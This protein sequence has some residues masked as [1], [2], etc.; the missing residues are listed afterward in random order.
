LTPA[1]GRGIIGKVERSAP[2]PSVL[3]MDEPSLEGRTLLQVVHAFPPASVTGTEQHVFG[4]S[5]ELARSNRVC[6]FTREVRPDLPEYTALDDEL[7]GVRVRRLTMPRLNG[8]PARLARICDAAL[9]GAFTRYLDETAPDL[10]HVHHALDLSLALATIAKRRGVP[11]VVTLHDY[12]FACPRIN[13]VRGDGSLCDGPRDGRRCGPC[14]AA[15]PP[16]PA[17]ITPGRLRLYLRHRLRPQARLEAELGAA[18]TELARQAAT[19][20]AHQGP[21]PG[22]H[23][24]LFALRRAWAAYQLAQ[25]D[26]L[27]A[28][29]QSTASIVSSQCPGLRPIR[30]V[31]HGIDV[32]RFRAV[33]RTSS[34]IVRF[35]FLGSVVKL[36]GVEVLLRAF[37]RLPRGAAALAI[38][39]IAR[40]P[41]F[42]E[43][44]RLLAG[45][46]GASM[47]GPY[48][49][50]DLARLLSEI[51]VVAV[52]SLV[53][54]SFGLVVR[55]AFAGGAPVIASRI[56]ALTEA[57]RDG[58]DGLL[59]KPG[60]AR[61][62]A[63]AM[64]RFVDEPGLL[65]AM[66]AHLPRVKTTAEN[67]AEIAAIYRELL[68]GPRS[69]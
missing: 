24:D 48:R 47:G 51:D 69:S 14:L 9:E 30:V 67:A 53:L 33:R 44:V 66:R 55:E 64:R 37:A 7:Q 16:S 5:R 38:H 4:L 17:P 36:K 35:G 57:V 50:E 39:G 10:V 23:R 63:A 61:A 13:L 46:A 42:A 40:D 8:S 11:V 32:E 54:E 19:L 20:A 26:A 27:V 52:P 31:A 12:Y 62:L 68:A 59:V 18:C 41:G 3:A 22:G 25:A 2:G 58:V 45:G 65:G 29:S 15:L 28:P 34:A 6:V 1:R 21:V 43:R 60:D 49:P 56:G